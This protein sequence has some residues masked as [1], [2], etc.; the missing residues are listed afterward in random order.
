MFPLFFAGL[1]CA[2]EELRSKNLCYMIYRPISLL[3]IFH[4]IFEKLM[5]HRLNA[6]LDSNDILFKSQYGFRKK[7][8]TQHAIPDIAN[9]MQ[10]NLD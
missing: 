5:F 8:S 2:I 1:V 3:S 9:A 4:M 10:S 6:F 7:Y